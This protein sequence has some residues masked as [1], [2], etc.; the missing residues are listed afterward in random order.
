LLYFNAYR[1][2]GAVLL[3][4]MAAAWRDALPFGSRDYRLFLLATGCYCVLSVVY[5]AVIRMRWRFE[6]QLTAQVMSDIAAITVLTYASGG[7]SSGLGLLMLTIVAAASLIARGKLTLFYAA[8]ASIALLLEHT[9]D[10]LYHDA[11][12]SQYAHAGLL[13]AAYFMV[14]WVAHTLAKYALESQE[15]AARREIDFENMAQVSEHVIRDMQDGVLVVD[16]H[17]VIRQFNASAERIA[18][19]L[20]GRRDVPLTEY[21]PEL[22]RRLE[23]WQENDHEQ[24]S[25]GQLELSRGAGAR[26]VQVGRRRSAGAVIF[27][28]DRTRIEAE[29]RQMKLVALGRL[30]ANIAHEV[31]NPLGAISH[32]AELLQEE[33]EVSDT[34]RR[35]ISIIQD[36]SQRLDRMVNDVLRL[37]R[38]DT[39][40]R[41]CFRLSDYLNTFVEQ[42]SQ[43]EKLD[44]AIFDIELKI[45][46]HV[47]F[48]RSHLNQ[49]MWNLCRNAVRHCRRETGSIR[50][51]VTREPGE[52]SVRIDVI[53]D[54][55]GVPAVLRSQ[56]FEPF[57]TTAKGGTGLG[58]YIA[59]EVCEANKARLEYVESERGAR[60]SVFCTA[61]ATTP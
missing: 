8:I 15:L 14:A 55:T 7:I 51:A 12:I 61:A 28:E 42:F 22:A 43:I 20:W 32:A 9:Y 4:A 50:I 59:R 1:L 52:S 40:H 45:D 29:A 49:V 46:P 24:A 3:L 11:A 37:R 53:D 21:S 54:G 48:D 16:G 35:L 26:F 10:V 27:L 58:L 25:A 36:N 5:F 23:A 19:P 31:R 34:A 44:P 57:F 17:G 18:G 39:A 60:F 2:V 41:E 47:F 6:V 30:T 56:L 33:P 13:A 38:S